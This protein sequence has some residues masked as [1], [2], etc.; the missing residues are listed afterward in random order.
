M[1]VDK[2]YSCHSHEAK[3]LKGEY[4][5]DSRDAMIK[6]GESGKPA[7]VP[8]EPDKSPLIK[9][10]KRTD[11]DEA[12]PPKEKDALSTEQVKDF[13]EWVKQGVPD[14]RKE[15]G[16]GRRRQASADGEDRPR[17]QGALGF[18][19]ARRAGG[20][21]SEECGVGSIPSRRIRPRE[22][23][24]QRHDARAA[25]GQAHADPP[26]VLHLIGLPPT[27][28]EVAAFEADASPDAFAKVVDRLLA[29]PHYGERW[30]RHWLDVARYADTK[31]YVFEE[32]RKYPYAY[33]YRDY[34]IRAFNEDLPYDQFLIQ[35]IAADRLD[36]GDDKRP[37]AAM[38]FLTLGRRFL[39]NQHGHHRR[40]DRRRDARDDGADRAV[41]PLPRPQ[42]RPDP[43]RGLLQ[44]V[45]RLRE[46]RRA[47]TP[48]R[49]S[50]RAPID[51]RLPRLREGTEGAGGG[52][53]GVPGREGRRR[54]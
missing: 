24:S 41:R 39:N 38:G 1:L 2:C 7:I 36:L 11:P 34:V 45:R 15:A 44:P 47:A 4:Y 53:R 32:E 6:G 23:R 31:G 43:D 8:G 35:Q 25:G 10:I 52:G 13:E 46:Q 21:R 5:L 48:C 54:R 51:R 26:G 16:Q 20:A 30:G 29:S 50:A 40:P 42:V 12:M 49:R 22:A 33:T 37:L 27:P 14:P 9:M 18:Q 19:E 17:R 28:E 3:K